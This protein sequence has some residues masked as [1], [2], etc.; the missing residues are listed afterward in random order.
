MLFRST[1][2]SYD[3]DEVTEEERSVVPDE[4]RPGKDGERR[5]SDEEDAGQKEEDEDCNK[6]LRREEQ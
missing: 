2:A 1:K 5:K 6:R 4:G 3:G